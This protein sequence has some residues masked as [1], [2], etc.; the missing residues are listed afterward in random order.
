MLYFKQW[1]VQLFYFFVVL[2]F[3]IVDHRNC[4]PGVSLLE[5]ASVWVH[6]KSYIADFV[7]LMMT[8]ASHYNS[9]FEFVNNG[10]LDFVGFRLFIGVSLTSLMQAFNLLVDQGEAI[11]D[12]K[13][14]RDIVDDK[15]KSTLE[16]PGGSK[17]AGPSLN[18]IVED[19]CF[20]AHEEAGV[21]SNLAKMG[22]AHLRFDDGVYE[23][24]GKGMVFHLHLVKF[25]ESKLRN[26]LD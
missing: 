11:V 10:F 24:E 17:E 21:S 14:F 23:I 3:E 4:G 18:S 2:L 16:D 7:R 8:I 22:I 13:I 19:F 1:L 6:V 20:R 9:T 15:V 25:V 5:L 26:A 12:G